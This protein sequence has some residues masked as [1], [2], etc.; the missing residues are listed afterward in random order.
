M[1]FSPITNMTLLLGAGIILCVFFHYLL[2]STSISNAITFELKIW[3]LFTVVSL[4]FGLI[5]AVSLTDLIHAIITFIEYLILIFSMVYISNQ[6]NKIDFFIN[7][8]IIFSAICALSVI[9]G[10]VNFTS[11]RMTMSETT[12]PNTVGI[13]L[14]IGIFCLLYQL[15]FKKLLTTLLRIGLLFLFLYVIVLTASRKSFISTVILLVFWILFVLKDV[16]KSTKKHRIRNLFIFISIIIIGINYFSSFLQDS[17][18]IVRMQLFFEGGNETRI[19]MYMTAFE[20]FKNNPIAG[21]GL[22]NFRDVTMFGTYS[23]STYAEILACT[24]L[25]GTILY[26]TPYISQIIKISYLMRDNDLNIAIH[27]KVLAGLLIVLMFLGT[28]VINFYEMYPNIAFGFVIAFCNLY[29]YRLKG[30]TS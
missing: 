25:I 2:N 24:G 11:T 1:V 8:Y 6:D 16:L 9:W 13:L 14:V 5:V 26:F 20:L 3:C 23:H 10:G 29:F 18:L 15:D 4:A 17:G 30:K 28:G 12:N 27:A 21:I 7:I 19:D 22:G